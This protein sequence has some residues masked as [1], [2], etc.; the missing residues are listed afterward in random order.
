MSRLGK[1]PIELPDKVKVTVSDKTVSAEG[2]AGKGSL[3][4]P[5]AITAEVEDG[6]LLKV[7][8]PS[9][10]KLEKSL[11]GTW[12]SHLANLVV[13]VSK[14][15]ERVLE[16][17]G[18]GYNAKVQ[19]TKLT[20]ALGFSHPVELDIPAGLK[21]E[22]ISPVVISVKGIN[23]QL[24]GE[25]SARIRAKRPAEPY[26]LKGI[27]YRDEVVRRKAGKTFVTGAS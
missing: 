20:M 27:K 26:N 3:V 16:I 18:V 24:V 11:W 23:K 9:S 7:S 22:C 2:P 13:G 6:K 5:G 14:G 12:R 1:K 25:F 4:L 15:Y 21:V 19:G 17:T 8:S 10:T